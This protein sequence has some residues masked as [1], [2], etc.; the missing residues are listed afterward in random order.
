MIARRKN[1]DVL[2]LGGGPVGLLVA[3]GL[4]RKGLDVVL[5]DRGP[6]DSASSVPRD[7]RGYALS[8]GSV[9][10]LEDLGLWSQLREESAAISAISVSQQGGL[11]RLMFDAQDLEVPALGW[12]IPAT[13]ITTAWMTACSH[14][15]VVLLGNSRFVDLGPPG[16]SRREVLLE[17]PDG[18]QRFSTRLLVAADG[19]D[20][21]VRAAAGIEVEKR[22]F[23]SSALV[24]D[25][26]PA[27]AHAGRAFE[28]FTPEGPLALLPMR[29]GAM[30]VVWVGSTATTAERAELDPE[31]RIRQ[32]QQAFGWSLGRLQGLGRVQQFPLRALR[33]KRLV[34]ARLALVGNAA[35]AVHPVAGQGLN[36]ALRDV[37]AL[38][39]QVVGQVDPGAEAAL[40]A[41]ARLRMPD[42]LQ[43]SLAT[44]QLA[45]NMRWSSSGL[46]AAS[47]GLVALLD[48]TPSLRR[49]AAERA[50]G[51]LPTPRRSLRELQSVRLPGSEIF[52]KPGIT[53]GGG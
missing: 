1:C 23:D 13:A 11:G 7:P 2:V 33:A 16:E 25:V 8:R 37:A 47:A 26:K 18:Q 30:N 38:L 51:L 32:L 5:A 48:R 40:A 24:L 46:V 49:L 34:A 27:R 28:R 36:L 6:L 9:Q 52:A 10:I 44:D 14:A 43:V 41:Y 17:G 29:T 12:V 22:D 45:R 35:H 3:L 31:T 20:S 19:A 42:I 39:G 4:G 50:M 53:G 21:G 15:G